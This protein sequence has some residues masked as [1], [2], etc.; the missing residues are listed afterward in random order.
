[1][2]KLMALQGGGQDDA[3]GGQDDSTHL[4]ICFLPEVPLF[5]FGGISAQPHTQT[6]IYP[7]P[8]IKNLKWLVKS[9]LMS[10]K[11]MS[12]NPILLQQTYN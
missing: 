6:Y 8:Y 4:R 3:Q 7:V 1:M 12:L 5:F 10:W 9:K 2:I 11:L